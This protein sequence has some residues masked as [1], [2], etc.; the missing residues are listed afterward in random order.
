MKRKSNVFLALLMFAA[1]LSSCTPASPAKD[2]PIKIGYLV[3]I[4]GDSALWG[5]AERDGAQIAADEINAA[6]GILGK[7]LDLAFYDG[8]GTSADSVNAVKKAIEQDGISVLL[9]SNLSGPTIAVADIAAKN[10]VPQIAS[11]ATNTMVTQTEDGKVRPW[12]FRLCFTDPYQG[13]ILANYA[14]NTLG[15][16]EAAILY[17]VTS[18]YSIG[19]TAAI[20]QNFAA[21]GGTIVAKLAYKGG[22]VDFRSQLTDIKAKNPK[23]IFLPNTY[24]ENALISKQAYDLGMDPV[25][26]SGDSYSPT[27]FEISPNLH[28]Y[29][30]VNHF[31][32]GDPALA[33]IKSKY[34]ARYKNDKPE[35]NVV[36]GYDMVY[37][38]KDVIEKAG[39][40]DAEKLRTAIENA[41]AIKL[42]HATITI[43]PATH[44]PLDKEAVILKLSDGKATFV[45]RYTPKKN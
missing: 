34:I 29:Y 21:A 32:W 26:L 23:A 27:M 43:D 8:R 10:K 45:E 15:I 40:T 42:T 20:E 33:D 38:I 18:D 4:T 37:F 30:T 9:G 13:R 3:H 24:K 19:I 35:L 12:S 36:M 11:F 5:I 44:N 41:T 17:D 31:D 39:T 2:A 22:D 1:I 14:V 6:G 7:K 28:D 25:F 16:K